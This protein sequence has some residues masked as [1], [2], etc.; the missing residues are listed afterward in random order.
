MANCCYY[1]LTV[2]GTEAAIN[3]LHRIMEYKD[4]EYYIYR[5]MGADLYDVEPYRDGLYSGTISGDVAWSTEHWIE[6]TPMWDETCRKLYI[7]LVELSRILG[8]SIELHSEECGCEFQEIGH[9]RHGKVLLFESSAWVD[10]EVTRE[11]LD[12]TVEMLKV[13]LPS[14]DPEEFRKAALERLERYSSA[15]IEAGGYEWVQDLGKIDSDTPIE[16]IPGGIV[17]K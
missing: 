1:Q 16:A 7:N 14:I 4:E 11:D 6:D 12:E 2:I 13:Q 3:R 5:V 8:L 17:V 15:F 9:I 10:L